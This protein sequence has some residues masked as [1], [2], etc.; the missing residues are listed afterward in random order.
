MCLWTDLA[1]PRAEISKKD[2]LLLTQHALVLLGNA[3]HNLREEKYCVHQD[4]PQPKSFCHRAIREEGGPTGFLEKTS[5]KVGDADGFSQ[6]LLSRHP[7]NRPGMMR[8]WIY[9]MPFLSRGISAKYGSRNQQEPVPLPVIK[10]ED[11]HS[12]TLRPNP[13][14]SSTC[15]AA[16]PSLPPAG[17]VSHCW[18]S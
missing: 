13:P 15:T 9:G 18:S 17:R 16:Q 10:Q 11:S 6:C 4:Q 8:R 12:V 7:E 1:N 14:E 3:S 2:T 5:K